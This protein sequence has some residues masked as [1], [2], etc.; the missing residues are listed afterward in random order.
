MFPTSY[1]LGAAQVYGGS[2]RLFDTL[3]TMS[4]AGQHLYVEALLP[5][6]AMMHNLKAVALP[7]ATASWESFHCCFDEAEVILAAGDQARGPHKR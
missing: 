7:E 1:Y 4:L 3:H 5:T 2:R 6:A